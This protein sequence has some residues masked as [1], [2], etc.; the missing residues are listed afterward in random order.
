MSRLQRKCFLASLLGHAAL[1]VLLVVSAGFS[2]GRPPQTEEVVLLTFIPDRLVDAPVI[3]GG[4]PQ[5]ASPP[6][7]REPVV[8]P[9]PPPATPPKP[10]PQPPP[11]AVKPKPQPEPEPP[12]TSPTG[13][14]PAPEP[15]RKIEVNLKPVVRQP[16][17]TTPTRDR[18]REDAEARQR[19]EAERLAQ[20]R[21]SQLARAVENLSRN[22]TSST[23]V[24]VPGTGGA[25]Y[26]SY[27]SYVD[28]VYRQAWAP[29]KPREINE[30]ALTV[31][32]RVVIARNGDV[33][34]SEIKRRSGNEAMDRSVRAALDRVRTIG[35]PF[36]EGAQDDRREFEIEFHLEPTPGA[37]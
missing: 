36:P 10:A 30:R 1:L 25:T 32:A 8:T 7:A 22:L 14:K 9:P 4:T 6:A 37:G 28:L 31:V 17:T 3:G 35:R 5:T 20:A 24:S 18:A 29:L 21:Q 13:E 12:K 26:A 2:T 27:T 15:R 11:Q 23:A 19:A 33:V 34:L 16:A